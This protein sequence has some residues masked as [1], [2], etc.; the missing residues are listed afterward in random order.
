MTDRRGTLLH[1][2]DGD[3]NPGWL[4]V[5]L[6]S[7]LGA[8]G[9]LV[10]FAIAWR[11]D[12]GAAVLIALGLGFV[13]FMVITAATMVLSLARVKQLHGSALLAKL[14]PGRANDPGAT[15]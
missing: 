15:P 2:P 14:A 4:I 12:S 5:L 8:I 13:A 1:E 7:V 6:F 10:A 11:K 9:C 3:F